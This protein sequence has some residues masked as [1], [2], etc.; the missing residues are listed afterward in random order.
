MA[1]VAGSVAKACTTVTM[2]GVMWQTI[3]HTIFILSAIGIAF[4]DKLMGQAIK[5]VRPA[6]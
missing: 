3:I 5:P 6:H 4:T 1:R 2:T